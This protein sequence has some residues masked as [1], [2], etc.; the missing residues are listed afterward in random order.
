MYR[1]KKPAKLF[2]DGWHRTGWRLTRTVPR[3]LHR[4]CQVQ[5]HEKAMVA[6]ESGAQIP[7]CLQAR[8]EGTHS[9]ARKH[10][11]VTVRRRL[12][13]GSAFSQRANSN[14]CVALV[15]NLHTA[16]VKGQRACPSRCIVSAQQ[17]ARIH[18]LTHTLTRPLHD[19]LEAVCGRLWPLGPIRCFVTP[20][21]LHPRAMWQWWRVAVSARAM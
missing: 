3:R 13:T 18:S 10:Q 15:P 4:V 1:E 7:P 16:A 17:Q 5:Y 20:P 11:P 21:S 19:T 14:A 12:C 8:S 9:A 6:W 2:D